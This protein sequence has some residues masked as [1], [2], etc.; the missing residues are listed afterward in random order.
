MTG[1]VIGFYS[2]ATVR[3][4]KIDKIGKKKYIPVLGAARSHG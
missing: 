4:W 2:G 3:N 1:F